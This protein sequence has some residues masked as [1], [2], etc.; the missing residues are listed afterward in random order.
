MLLAYVDLSWAALVLALFSLG[1][2]TGAIKAN[3]SAF[4]TEQYTGPEETTRVLASGEEV[5]VDKALTIQRFGFRDI[6]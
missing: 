2:G 3:V 1:I 4:V 5:I 6:F